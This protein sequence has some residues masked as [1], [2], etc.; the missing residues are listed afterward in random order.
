[1]RKEK[2]HA[3]CIFDEADGFCTALI[4]KKCEGCKFRKSVQEYTAAQEEAEKLLNDRGLEAYRKRD[5]NGQL[6]ITTRKVSGWF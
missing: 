2:Y 6:I 4:E 5:R 3:P 1:M